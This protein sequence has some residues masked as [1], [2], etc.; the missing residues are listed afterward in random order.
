MVD[1]MNF[2][3][4][5]SRIDKELVKQM[6]SE[7]EYWT[8][9]LKRIV[10]VIRFLAERGLPFRGTNEV[11]GS[12]DNGNYLGIIELLAQFDPLLKGHLINYANKGR[13]NVSYLSKTICEE[14]ID[15]MSKKVLNQII[16]EI[17]SAKYWGIIVDSTPDLSHVD[18]LSVI[19]RYYLN[20]HVHERFVCFL[21]IKSHTGEQQS[22]DILRLLEKYGLNIKDCRA[23]TYDNASNMSGKYSGLQACL[24]KENELAVY[25]PCVGHSLNLVGECSVNENIHSANFFY[26]LQNLYNF[27]SS[28]THRWNILQQEN[29]KVTSLSITRWSKRADAVSALVNNFAGIYNALN[30]LANDETQKLDTRHEASSLKN[31]IIKLENAFMAVLWHAILSRFDATNSYLQKVELDLNVATIMM[32]SLIEY[33]KNLRGDFSKIEK[34]SKALNTVIIQEYYDVNKRK[35][36]KKLNDGEKEQEK[37]SGSDKF[38]VNTFYVIVDK[39]IAEM[40]KRIEAYAHITYTFGFFYV[41]F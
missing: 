10:A 31:K 14:L 17:K 23:Q 39:L 13:G 33:L 3:Q 27:F 25:V 40:H 8:E 30:Q 21:Q 24:K 5:D 22:I 20:G 19:F 34:N 36:T 6:E 9:I 26:L 11:I 35:I 16:S 18:Q 15:L 28:S 4:K 1:W 37:L 38:R 29:G 2:L 12:P 41:I 32:F 7:I